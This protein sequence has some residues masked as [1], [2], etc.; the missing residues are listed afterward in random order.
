MHQL[1]HGLLIPIEGIDGSGKSTL[2]HNLFTALNKQLPMF[3][4]KEPGGSQLGKQL[5]TILQ[6]QTIP[7]SAQAEYLL[8][9]ADRAQH[10]DEVIIPNLKQKKL[11]ISDRMCDSSLVYQG[12]GRGLDLNMIKKIN[13]WVMKDIK[14]DL[15]IYVRIPLSIAL[16]RIQARNEQLTAFEREHTSFLE[17]LI[18]GFDAIYKNRKDVI[19]IDGNQKPEQ[20]LQQTLDELYSWIQKN[21]L[22]A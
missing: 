4:T 11:I 12:Y 3:L 8:F 20:V 16:K 10:F 15:T 7:V 1:T 21:K 6:T 13:Q 14:T 5:R 22:I 17:K 19:F 18:V 9:A 2:A